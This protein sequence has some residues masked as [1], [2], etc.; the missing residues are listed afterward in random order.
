[1][2][3]IKPKILWKQ[4]SCTRKPFRSHRNLNPYFTA[5]ELLV[6]MFPFYTI[7]T[8]LNYYF[9][10]GYMNMTPAQHEFVVQDCTEAI[11]LDS[12]YVKALNRRAL[13]LENLGRYQEALIGG[14]MS[15]AFYVAYSVSY[16]YFCFRYY[17]CNNSGQIPE[18]EH[19]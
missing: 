7:A 11:K 2:Q 10:P 1:M 14:P 15:Y 16:E 3:H 4:Q 18:P 6:R 5:I 19:S 8:A 9:K 17:G 12:K 13:A